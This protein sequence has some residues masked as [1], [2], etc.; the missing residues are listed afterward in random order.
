MELNT[1]LQA[2]ATVGF[3]IVMCFVLFL[4]L[5][6]QNKQHLEETKELTKAIENNTQA[7]MKLTCLLDTREM[8]GGKL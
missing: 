3:P 2:V 7:T 1:V 5:V 8:R 6:E 4:Y